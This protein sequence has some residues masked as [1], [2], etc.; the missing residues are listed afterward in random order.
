MWRNGSARRRTHLI[1]FDGESANGTLMCI[2]RLV[3]HGPAGGTDVVNIVQYVDQ[4]ERRQDTWRILDRQVRILWS[5]AH[6]T[7]TAEQTADLG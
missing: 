4:Y 5:E 1:E 3:Q 2:A 6:A 7:M